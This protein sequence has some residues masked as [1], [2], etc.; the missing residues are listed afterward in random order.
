M[1]VLLIQEEE[2]LRE[3]V[4]FLIES[5]FQGLVFE[6]D[7]LT[8]S[9]QFLGN[10][11]VSLDLIVLDIND[12]KKLTPDDKKAFSEKV[13]SVPIFL[14][15]DRS[16]GGRPPVTLG[17]VLGVLD[18]ANIIEELTYSIKD[19]IKKG[20]L[21]EEEAETTLCRIKTKLLLAVYPL[22]SDLYIRLSSQ[23]YVKLFHAGDVFDYDDLEKYT[24][25]RGVNYLYLPRAGC[26]EFAAK[27]QEELKKLLA[28][29]TLS[30]QEIARRDEEMHDTV[31]EL[32]SVVGFTSQV[33]E[34][35][36]TQVKVTLK[37][38]RETSNLAKAISKLKSDGGLYIS[39]HSTLCAY[40]SCAIATQ[41][42][43]GS[44]TTFHK[45]TLASFLHDIT[46]KNHEIAQLNTLD[47]LEAV[48]SKYT[49]EE[50]KEFK[51]HPMKAAEIV[52]GMTE[53]PPD[54]DLIIRQHHERPDGSGFPRGLTHS[55]IAPLSAVFIVAHDMT[56]HM[57]QSNAMS[58]NEFVE[59]VKDKYSSNQF[60][61]ILAGI[62]DLGKVIS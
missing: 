49:E 10:A 57:I 22:S 51:N 36:K 5:I 34:L 44:D 61:R 6:A 50:I 52:G 42:E 47:E 33:Q 12:L 17:N 2:S 18:R 1:K 54:V 27:Y 35:A 13:G 58:V 56:Q 19:Q 31:Q 15:M 41:I 20:I 7:S 9:L 59:K 3:K 16:R 25:K 43:W 39:A 60:K 46:L 37:S 28:A 8:E 24:L 48:K 14:S 62:E 53:V 30:F 45:L 23:K 55:Y 29:K 11:A 40:L 26:G 38:I 4:V 21:K 32:F